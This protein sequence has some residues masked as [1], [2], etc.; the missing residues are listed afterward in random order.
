MAKKLDIKIRETKD[1]AAR[2]GLSH[3]AAAGSIMSWLKSSVKAGRH[4]SSW[5][6]D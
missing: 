4:I 5:G 6:K 1:P 2:F 3:T